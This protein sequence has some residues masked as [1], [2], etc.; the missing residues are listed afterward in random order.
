MNSYLILIVTV[1]ASGFASLA[2]CVPEDDSEAVQQLATTVASVSE[3]AVEEQSR[4]N[5]RV[6][7]ATDS[8]VKADSE[9]RTAMIQAHEHIQL[10]LQ[11]ERAS[12]DQRRQDLDSL[13]DQVEGERLRTPVIAES[14][15]SV[16]GM[17]ACL[18]PLLLAA[19]ILYSMNLT[20]ETDQERIVNQFL[21]QEL[22]S[23]SPTLLPAVAPS[24][25]LEDQQQQHL[26]ATLD[27]ESDE[28]PPF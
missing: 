14:I 21:I 7:D 28:E 15:Q 24:S 2:G 18:C 25:L 10:K 27:P 4:L 9:A 26:L 22:T 19:Y 5:L 16:G 23:D 3:K 11:A 20:I 17:F 12:L 8:L 13:K 1:L 6:A